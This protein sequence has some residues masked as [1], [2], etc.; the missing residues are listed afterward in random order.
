MKSNDTES[1][2][3]QA[4]DHAAP[5]VFDK[6]LMQIEGNAALKADVGAVSTPAQTQGSEAKETLRSEQ[7]T[8][9]VR[10]QGKAQSTD[11]V[12]GTE[13]D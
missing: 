5:D 10:T 7:S 6:I 8:G 3:K 1:K 13:T 4:F 2:I 12:R 9:A 11:E